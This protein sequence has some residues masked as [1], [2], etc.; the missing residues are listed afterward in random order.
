[1]VQSKQFFRDTWAEVEL[2]HVK[3]NV[4]EVR[5]NFQQDMHVMAVVKADGYGHGAVPVAE[6]ALEAGASF[7]SVNLLDEALRLREAGIE[8][9][10]LVMGRIRPEDVGIAVRHNLSITVFQIEWLQEAKQYM[11]EQDSLKLHV[12]IDSGMGRIG[13]V[14]AEELSQLLQVIETDQAFQ[15]EAVYTHFATADELDNS[16]WEKQYGRF[17]SRLKVVEEICGMPPFIH[18]GNS[19]TGL[20]F[21]E[22]C[23]NM[24]RFGISMYGLLPSDDIEDEL[25]FELK[26]AF[27]LHSQ[28]VQVKQ[29]P[30]GE[31]ISYGATYTTSGD[32]W[33]GT[34]PIGYADGWYRYHSSEGGTVLV[35]GER[36]PIIG[37]ICMDQLMVRLPYQLPVGTKVTL[38]GKQGEDEITIQEIASRL[39]T[40]SYEI[41]CMISSRV[42]RLYV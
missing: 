14:T 10:I 38:I 42:P 34:V 21:P 12:K 26:R 30:K 15:L 40:I 1:M 19:A 24:F 11:K 2:A 27:S 37:R 7:L 25:P 4:Q 23:F 41:P 36:A 5:K 13:T 33:I 6:A 18:C 8:A 3:Y 32:E 39:K 16:Y 17:L 20:R 31:G 22:H 28:L 9:P 29:L 35:D